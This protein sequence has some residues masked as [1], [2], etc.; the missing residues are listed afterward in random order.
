MA[1]KIAIFACIGLL[2]L[3]G[4]GINSPIPLWASWIALAILLKG[5]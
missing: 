4:L 3:G 2:V 1:E 5:H